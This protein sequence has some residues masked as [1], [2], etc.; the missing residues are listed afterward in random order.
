MFDNNNDPDHLLGSLEYFL[1]IW[2]NVI[3]TRYGI[4]EEKLS[5]TRLPEPLQRL[6]AFSGKWP[7]KNGWNT[8]FSYQDILCP[9]ELLAIHDGNLV[10]SWENQGVWHAGTL[11]DGDDPPV[12][13]CFDD[14]TWSPLCKSL[15]QFLVTLCLRETLFGCE[16]TG[17]QDG[18]LAL[19]KENGKH[20]A[21]LWLDGCYVNMCGEP[22]LRQTT[23]HLIDRKILV[24]SNNWCGTNSPEEAARFPDLFKPMRTQHPDVTPGTPLW[25]IE[26]VPKIIKKAHLDS[27]ARQ[28][29]SQADY[30]ATQ[31]ANYRRIAESV[32]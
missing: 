29:D 10:F 27:L 5:V 19:M 11:P 12:F 7:G 2:H 31:A 17:C 25:E 14:K 9:F 4:A 24:M 3:P 13:V 32:Q 15:T 20:V 28:H 30:H 6:Y 26:F 21:P 18:V 16:H 22:R 23:F 8:P 1:Q